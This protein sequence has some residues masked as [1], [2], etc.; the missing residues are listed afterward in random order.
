M[1]FNIKDG[2]KFFKDTR[3][4]ITTQGEPIAVGDRVVDISPD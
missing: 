1:A 2:K 3:G 4:T